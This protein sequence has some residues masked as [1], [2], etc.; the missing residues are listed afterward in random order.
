M[1][2]VKYA[3]RLADHPFGRLAMLV[4]GSAVLGATMAFYPPFETVVWWAFPTVIVLVGVW[5]LYFH[6]ADSTLSI[7]AGSL[8]VLGGI[9]RA[10]YQ[11]VPMDET[12][13]TVANLVPAFGVFAMMYA[14]HYR[15]NE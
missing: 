7:V 2:A 12:T 5:E 15:E 9:S 11:L 3:D 14:Q 10:L 13:G 1:N 4:V 8:F 6:G